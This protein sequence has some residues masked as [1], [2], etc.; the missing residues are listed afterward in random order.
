VP[1]GEVDEDVAIALTATI[2]AKQQQQQPPQSPT[3]RTWNQ[4]SSPTPT[5]RQA[6]QDDARVCV[7]CGHDDPPRRKHKGD[8]P[9]SRIINWL[10]CDTF[11]QWLHNVCAGVGRTTPALFVC[12]SCQ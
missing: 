6:T 12:L 3:L 10:Q 11:R 1:A 2:T 4:A 9:K 7:E 5:F 8:R